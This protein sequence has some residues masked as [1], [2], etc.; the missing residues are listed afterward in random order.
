[1]GPPEVRTIG[2]VTVARSD[3]GIYRPILRALRTCP[4][5]C[6]RLFVSGAH[7]SPHYGRTVE[8]IEAESGLDYVAIESLLSTD[9]PA[10]V[11]KSIA[12]G[13]S[14]FADAFGR[15][16][17]DLLV[18]LGDRFDMYAA[19]VAALP[20]LIPVAH[21]HGGE[22]T[23]GAIDDALRHSMTK[24]SHLHFCS[25]T[26]Y[27]RRVRQL[28][29]EQWRICVSGAPGLDDVRGLASTR[30]EDLEAHIGRALA[31]P[32]V[33]VTYHPVTLEPDAAGYQV[34]DLL[35]ALADLNLPALITMPNADTNNKAIRTEILEWV[36]EHPD[37]I[38]CENL[39]SA[40]YFAAMRE[41][42]LMV[43]NSSSGIIE[44]ASFHLPVVNVGTRQAGRLQP[45]NVVS[46]GS[47]RSAVK[48][49]IRHALSPVFRRRC[50]S[51]KNPYFR[52][53]AGR[54]IAQVLAGI[55]LDERLMRKKFVD[56]R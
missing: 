2:V 22:I 46:C 12:V 16:R 19:A 55:P 7:L 27:A 51:L 32:F 31:Q 39:G 35:G 47:G 17:P 25:T 14:G 5:V 49:A 28:G 3:W 30:R 36:R 23:E 24:L 54:R 44:A 26:A 56:L 10:G 53:G 52:P 9:T 6:V 20:F 33:L 1:M 45:A 48:K 50:R 15:F 41:A 4:D 29:E 21:V 38:A 37:S 42:L 43:G 18:V 11:V 40:R 13:L 34:R 8:I